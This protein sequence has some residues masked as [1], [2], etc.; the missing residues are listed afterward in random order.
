MTAGSTE[1]VQQLSPI[2]RKFIHSLRELA[3]FFTEHPELPVPTH[4]QFHV[5]FYPSRGKEGLRTFAKAFEGRGGITQHVLG[6]GETHAS[7]QFKGH[8]GPFT[9]WTCA[10]Q[11][12]VCTSRQVGT[13]T[14]PAVSAK[15]AVPEHEEPIIEWECGSI[16]NPDDKPKPISTE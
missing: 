7:L 2:Q 3:Y 10:P 13:R 6:E 14:V 15:P 4:T 16:L 9:I 12:E 8:I 1:T 11:S 5:Y